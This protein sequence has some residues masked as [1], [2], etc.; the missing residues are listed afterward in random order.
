MVANFFL[1]NLSYVDSQ[2]EQINR[3]CLLYLQMFYIIGDRMI[4][5]KI[6]GG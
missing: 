3:P 2:V 4:D 5:C 1:I 6:A